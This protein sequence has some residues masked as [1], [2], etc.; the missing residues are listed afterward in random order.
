MQVNTPRVSRPV[1]AGANTQWT[2][3]FISDAFA[4]G[5]SFRVLSIVDEFT[6]EC[7]VLRA[8][9]S[10][11]STKV[12]AAF[13]AVASSRGVRSGS[14]STTARNSWRRSWMP[15]V[16]SGRGAP[17]SRGQPSPWATVSSRAFTTSFATSAWV[18]IGFAI[19]P[20]RTDGSSPGRRTTTPCGRTRGSGVVPPQST[21]HSWTT[22]LN[23]S[24]LARPQP[25]DSLDPHRGA[26]PLVAP[27]PRL[28]GRILSAGKSTQVFRHVPCSLA[29]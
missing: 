11:P 7:L 17:A 3:D 26:G 10:Q 20:T 6:R 25:T 13:E 23:S 12:V 9:V 19:F 2:L 27:T 16:C 8:D 14:S 5:R 21:Q 22:T 29:L 4:S 24:R 15:G 18:R 1:A 28:L